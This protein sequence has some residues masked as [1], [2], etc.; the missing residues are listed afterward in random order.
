VSATG[1]VPELLAAVQALMPDQ[2]GQNI[3]GQTLERALDGVDLLL[4]NGG[5]EHFDDMDRSLIRLVV[6]VHD[7][8]A[9]GAVDERQLAR[10]IGVA[11]TDGEMLALIVDDPAPAL[12][13][14]SGRRI[15]RLQMLGWLPV[16]G[17]GVFGASTIGSIPTTDPLRRLGRS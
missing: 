5:P 10:D 8:L 14:D 3:D 4:Q 13:P 15:R 9:G 2:G 17:G 7:D 1:G 16:V 11:M 6:E 12:D